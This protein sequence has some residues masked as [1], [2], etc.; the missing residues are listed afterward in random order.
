MKNRRIMINKKKLIWVVGIIM[1][2]I[3][4]SIATSTFSEYLCL[5]KQA[6]RNEYIERKAIWNVSRSLTAKAM[7]S[8]MTMVAKGDS[9]LVCKVSCISLNEYSD[10][11]KDKA[12]PTRYAW[13]RIREAYMESLVNGVDWMERRSKSMPFT[14][15]VIWSQRRFDEQGRSRKSFRQSMTSREKELNAL[16]PRN[17]DSEEAYDNWVNKYKSLFSFTHQTGKWILSFNDSYFK[18]YS[19]S[20]RKRGIVLPF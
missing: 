4:G 5:I 17:I 2:V 20:S 8:N 19:V 13:V 3:V 18:D 12:Q 16:Y 15:Y 10:F 1:I 6:H 14:S 11:V 9:V 7:L